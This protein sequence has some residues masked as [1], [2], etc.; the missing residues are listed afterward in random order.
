M[1]EQVLRASLMSRVAVRR[2]GPGPC[3]PVLRDL[4]NKGLLEKWHSLPLK[5]ALQGERSGETVEKEEV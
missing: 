5:Q 2:K 3:S 4:E 1:Y